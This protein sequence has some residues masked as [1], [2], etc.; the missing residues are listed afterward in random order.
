MC[1]SNRIS[2]TTTDLELRRNLHSLF[3]SVRWQDQTTVVRLHFETVRHTVI[4]SL[5][6][7]LTGLRV[8]THSKASRQIVRSAL[9]RSNVLPRTRM[10]AVIKDQTV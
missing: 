1:I 8:W 5:G 2:C 10:T 4:V 7:E 9:N 3:T 6:Q